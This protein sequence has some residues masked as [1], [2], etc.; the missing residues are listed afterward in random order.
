VQTN[1]EIQMVRKRAPGG[2]RKPAGPFRGKN[3][4][5]TTRIKSETRG[6]LEAAAR[7][8]GLSLSQEAERRLDESFRR[9]VGD[10]PRHIAALA[11]LIT[12]VAQRIESETGKDWHRDAFTREAL[13]KGVDVLLSHFGAPGR[14]TV[15]PKVV[16]AA[17]KLPGPVSQTYKTAEGLGLLQAGVVIFTIESSDTPE[18]GR[19]ETYRNWQLLRDLGS[20]WKMEQ[21]K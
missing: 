8:S 15:P 4:N 6:A 10:R 3:A 1:K 17:A 13:R 11:P 19:P 7:K 20:G 14:A 5:L 21:G 12:L 18:T 9:D 16:A 2:G